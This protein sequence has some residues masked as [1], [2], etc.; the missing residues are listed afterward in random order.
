MQFIALVVR[1]DR[2]RLDQVLVLDRRIVDL[3]VVVRNVH[4]LLADQLPGVTLRR[5]V[6][7]V[8]VVDGAQAGRRH[9]VIEADFRRLADAANA[10]LILPGDRK[11]T[12]LNSSNYCESRM[13]S[14]ARKK[15]KDKI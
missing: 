11:S 3:E 8:V 6:E 7:H 5:A 4:F 12:R 10:R 14:S 1:I 15:K 13:P 9:R 2:V